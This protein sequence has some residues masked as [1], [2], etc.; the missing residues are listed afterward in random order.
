MTSKEKQT[1]VESSLSRSRLNID[2]SG[3]QS[4][5]RTQTSSLIEA[6]H[7]L[8]NSL[9]TIKEIY[10]NKITEL[11]AALQ[12]ANEKIES[13][14]SVNNQKL[15]VSVAPTVT[16]VVNDSLFENVKEEGLVSKVKPIVEEKSVIKEPVK[17]VAQKK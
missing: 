7:W 16:A 12:A 5:A 2:L 4:N 10:D 17:K 3:K 13:L 15:K 14:S 1:Y 8:H 11:E 9:S 6:V